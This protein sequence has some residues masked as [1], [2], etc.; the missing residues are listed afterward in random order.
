MREKDDRLDSWKEICAYIGRSR[1]TCLKWSK[2]FDFPIYRIDPRSIRSSV[3]SY[4]SE[5]ENWFKMKRHNA[6]Q[7]ISILKQ[8]SNKDE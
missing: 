2:E 6:E 1:P 8:S 4:K 5:I 3:F 7:I